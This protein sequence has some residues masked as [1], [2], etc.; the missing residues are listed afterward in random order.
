MLRRN[1]L[2]LQLVAAI[3]LILL[4]SANLAS[5][6]FA[7]AGT[8]FD[9]TQTQ[10]FTGKFGR[11]PV[12]S[13]SAAQQAPL[14]AHG[15]SGGQTITVES[16]SIVGADPADFSIINDGCANFTFSLNGCANQECLV[17]LAFE[18]QTGGALK[19]TLQSV[20]TSNTATAALTGTGGII[21]SPLDGDNF[22]IVSSGLENA[23]S[24]TTVP[25][26]AAV[27][28]SQ[29]VNWKTTIKYAT[30]GGVAAPNSVST[31]STSG[32]QT[33]NN[34]Y[35]AV[36]G[37]MTIDATAGSISDEITVT[38]SGTQ[39]D[40][41]T[42]SPQLISDYTSENGQ[43]PGTPNLFTL[44]AMAESSYAPFSDITLYGYDG[45]W[46]HE[47]PKTS[48]HNAGYNI[49]LMMASLSNPYVDPMPTA[50]DWVQNATAGADFFAQKV[51]DEVTQENTILANHTGLSA[52]SQPQLEDNALGRYNGNG[53]AASN[54]AWIVQCVAGTVNATNCKGGTWQWVENTGSGADIYAQTVRGQ[55][56]P[57]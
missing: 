36:G 6:A 20:L 53:T 46:P 42:I 37:Q 19:G 32:G 21:V 52:L 38:L 24:P 9:L 5:T 56:P 2:H 35:S 30:S 16:T 49:G 26:T 48:S 4:V 27:S 18:P 34:Q 22:S 57:C 17:T 1:Y 51:A 11:V 23:P 50:W 55:Q 29:T 44:I 40:D 10:K 33:Q 25:F 12:G 7:Q 47:S 15:L 14:C 28:S 54:Q 3:G 8:D 43:A 13:E 31:F 41:F 45:L 39:I